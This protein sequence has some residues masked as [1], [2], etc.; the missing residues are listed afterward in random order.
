[1]LYFPGKLNINFQHFYIFVTS[2]LYIAT[3]GE[4]GELLWIFIV[5]IFTAEFENNNKNVTKWFKLCEN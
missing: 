3:L 1:M 4:E 2:K 5:V